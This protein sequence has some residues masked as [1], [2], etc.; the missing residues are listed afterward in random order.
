MLESLG[1]RD[2]LD[3][4]AALKDTPGDQILHLNL[5]G[6]DP[7]DAATPVAYEKG[8]AFLRM[9][10]HRVGRD[11]FDTWLVGYFNRHAFTSLTTAQFLGDFRENLL[12]N[13]TDL[14]ETMRVAEWLEQ[15]GLPANATVPSSNAFARVEAEAQRFKSGTSPRELNTS[16]WVTQQWQHF[17]RVLPEPL[18][19]QQL[20]QLDETFGFSRTGNSEVLFSCTATCTAYGGIGIAVQGLVSRSS[21]H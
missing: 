19:E 9:V 8:A 15:P 2:L 6:R 7:D 13:D 11:R 14:E 3:K 1:R 17:L 10:E 21:T 5:N 20:Q 16:G 18:R 4:L 12:T